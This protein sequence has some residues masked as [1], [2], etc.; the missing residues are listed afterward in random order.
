M[1]F[2]VQEVHKVGRHVTPLHHQKLPLTLGPEDDLAEDV[3]VVLCVPIQKSMLP[4]TRT[5]INDEA[6]RRGI[7]AGLC[8]GRQ[9]LPHV[10]ADQ[11]VVEVATLV[12]ATPQPTQSLEAIEIQELVMSFDKY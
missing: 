3:L 11:E 4:V 6:G 8:L 7:G 9:E 12:S 2:F 10:Q 1:A 5:H